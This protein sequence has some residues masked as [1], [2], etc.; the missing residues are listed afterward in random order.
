MIQNTDIYRCY[1]VKL[2][3]FLLQQDIKYFLVARDIVSNK[4]F[5]AFEK[6]KDFFDAFDK[7]DIN[8][9]KKK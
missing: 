7:W 9:P 2:K 5:Y 4:K 1:D 8:N 6:T 3:D